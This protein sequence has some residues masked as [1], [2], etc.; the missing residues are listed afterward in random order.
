MEI[1][2]SNI[3]FVITS[4]VKPEN[5]NV[6]FYNS[7][8]RYNQTCHTISSIKQKIPGAKIVVVEASKTMNGEKIYFH[9]VDMFYINNED[10]EKDK[11]RGECIIL[12]TFFQS[13]FFNKYTYVN[14]VFKISGRYYLNDMFDINNFD[15]TKINARK[16]DTKN[17]PNQPNYNH[18]ILYST[19]PDFCHVTA[20]FCFP[21]CKSSIISEY[22]ENY[23]K[24]GEGADIEHIL[25]KYCNEIHNVIELGVSGN[26]A[27]NGKF[28]KY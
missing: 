18:N 20:L 7:T 25:F 26:Q 14:F 21:F 19:D 13:D 24:N 15:K 6:S 11:S 27:P 1:N 3:L 4:I 28:V 17:D 10:V 12:K 5:T 2:Y 16:V 22:L 23:I 8:E 9:G